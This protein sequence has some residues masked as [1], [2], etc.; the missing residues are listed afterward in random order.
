MSNISKKAS[1]KKKKSSIQK[2]KRQG[3]EETITEEAIAVLTDSFLTS[4]LDD[5]V[6]LEEET[7]EAAESKGN[8]VEL[9]PHRSKLCPDLRIPR[10][11]KLKNLE[12]PLK[13]GFKNDA[14]I[15]EEHDGTINES[16]N[17]SSLKTNSSSSNHNLIHHYHHRSKNT[18]KTKESVSVMLLGMAGNLSMPAATASTYFGEEAREKFFEQYHWIDNQRKITNFHPSNTTEALY[19]AKPSTANN[20][21]GAQPVVSVPFGVVRPS[22]S[23]PPSPSQH[24]PMVQSN[25]YPFLRTVSSASSSTK[26]SGNVPFH[27]GA[28]LGP[29]GG[30]SK[31]P[32][33]PLVTSLTP[34]HPGTRSDPT[35]LKGSHSKSVPLFHSPAL[36][37]PH[38]PVSP[39]SLTT[40]NTAQPGDSNSKI[41]DRF[42][43]ASY[44][45]EQKYSLIEQMHGSSE[46]DK[47]G[48]RKVLEIPVT[49]HTPDFVHSLKKGSRGSSK[50]KLS[51]G[52]DHA[53]MSKS[54]STIDKNLPRTLSSPSA[55]PSMMQD[56]ANSF[57]APQFFGTAAMHTRTHSSGNHNI[58]ASS[59]SLELGNVD[60]QNSIFR[61]HKHESVMEEELD[62]LDQITLQS[63]LLQHDLD[64]HL[65]E[66]ISPRSIYLAACSRERV[67]PR[68]S[69]ILRKGFNKSLDL[70]NQAVGD[71]MG[72]ILAECIPSMPYLQSLN[73]KDNRLTDASLG[74]ILKALMNVSGLLHLDIS[75]N[76]MDDVSSETLA[77]Y[78][79]LETCPLEKLS[80][81]SADVDDN[82]GAKFISVLCHNPG[83]KLRELDMSHNLL[84]SLEQLNT[85]MENLTTAGEAFGDLFSSPHCT[86]EKVF[87]SWNMIRLDSGI[88]MA[89]SLGKNTSVVELDMSSN[90]LGTNGGLALASSL[91]SNHTIRILNIVNNNID[92][93]ACFAICAAICENKSLKS[94]TFDENPIG[95]LG[96][97][98]LMQIPTV[99]G[100]RV[101]LSA[102]GCNTSIRQSNPIDFDFA[103]IIRPYTLRLDVPFERA[104]ALFLLNLVACHHT[105]IFT[106]F[107]CD[108]LCTGKYES[109]DLVPFLHADKQAHF[110]ESQQEVLETLQG[111]LAA[112]A[113]RNMAQEFF[114]EVD[115]DGSGELERDEF[116]TLLESI[117]IDIDD[118]RLDEIFEYYDTD[119]GGTIGLAEFYVFLKKQHQ[120]SLK[121]LED[122]LH[123]PAFCRKGCKMVEGKPDPHSTKY[124]PPST[125]RLIIKVE[126]GF[127]R[128]NIFRIIS[129][130]DKAHIEAVAAHCTDPSSMTSHGV[131]GA[132]LRVEEAFT[133]FKEMEQ[134]SRNKSKILA[135]LLPQLSQPEDARLL[136]T[137]A[138]K[139]DRME[140]MKLRQAL[141][142]ALRPL[143]GLCNGYYVLDLSKPLERLCLM[144]LLEVSTT[145]ADRLRQ[146]C[147]VPINRYSSDFSQKKN[148]NSCFR[149]E[150][151]T[152][153]GG[154]PRSCV[155]DSKFASPLPSSGTLSFDFSGG[156]RPD[157]DDML[158]SDARVV[159]TLSSLFLL[160]ESH[161]AGAMIK[162]GRYKRHS[163]RCLSGGGHTLYECSWDRAIAIGDAK[164]VFYEEKLNREEQYIE[165]IQVNE[166]VQFA[167]DSAAAVEAA[168]GVDDESL[169][170]MLVG[171]I[172]FKNDPTEHQGSIYRKKTDSGLDTASLSSI[173]GTFEPIEISGE[174]Q[175]FLPSETEITNCGRSSPT[176]ETNTA[177]TKLAQPADE[178]QK[179]FRLF[180]LSKGVVIAAKAAR[181]VDAIDGAFN[182]QWLVC[183]HIALMCEVFCKLGNRKRT[184]DFGSYRS[185]IV[186]LLFERI[187]DTHNFDLV[188]RVLEPYEVAAVIARI[189]WLNIFN[190][191]KPEGCIELNLAIYEERAI[192]KMLNTLATIEPGN[193]WPLKQFKWKY[194]EDPMPGWELKQSWME[195]LPNGA[196]LPERGYLALQY[197]SGDGKKLAGCFPHIKLRKGLMHLVNIPEDSVRP[198]DAEDDVNRAD[199]S[200]SANA[201]SPRTTSPGITYI[202]QNEATWR[203]Y[204]LL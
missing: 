101:A 131:A 80:M 137:K 37:P 21:N 110:D 201:R 48:R 197:Y 104:A 112:C 58:H 130:C 61:K 147:K 132:K 170:A 27:H 102:R 129:G 84:G 192:V 171:S 183:R 185:E 176:N 141:G 28:G 155:V 156:S 198:E 103:N 9:R 92:A 26:P 42:S 194:G 193:N 43:S 107:D 68:A 190:P 18:S 96:A 125:G 97:K 115:E 152:P 153:V 83:S 184:Q 108:P 172:D 19:F 74:P 174:H 161:L 139:G 195:D 17:T 95:V 123:S 78:L 23:S 70:H 160:S 29:P 150:I 127:T 47:R 87:V 85:V 40:V 52:A 118:E 154:E 158:T 7:N 71:T 15:E 178:Y 16:Q 135:K 10:G 55:L 187:V 91:M 41:G 151:F 200:N 166:E 34:W 8:A 67:N 202:Q 126:D 113:D 50:S 11:L 182:K 159:K 6:K 136:V 31:V 44:T 69:M 146:A 39:Q 88:A 89:A 199:S 4:L 173:D 75:N 14:D 99:V 175:V 120:D 164:R 163:E 5:F 46:L 66:P 148:N 124:S 63:H 181:M 105:F 165:A 204:L 177:I 35:G 2:A 76:K 180:L 94:V 149:N 51:K 82:E 138:L 169:I 57:G 62:E 119:Q 140:M 25:S 24:L 93:T 77:T 134:E 168:K 20:T 191:M 189:G 30:N 122:H 109:I 188:L 12:L 186:A 81:S 45:S 114:N 157:P 49:V 59:R 143:L 145:R 72:L 196:G 121:R 98:A 22:S 3:N 100:S 86:L 106:Q 128:K 60:W 36:L 142:A 65:S 167:Y 73:L 1:S 144:R 133:I 56:G 32:A 64:L 203:K 116:R 162:L 53:S 90:A 13:L 79:G 33:T 111:L 117:G 179:K 54:S 38:S